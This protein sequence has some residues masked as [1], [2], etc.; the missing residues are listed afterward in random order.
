[1]AIKFA[2]LGCGRIGVLHARNL[3]AA[4]GARLEVVFD[5]NTAV[6]HD[7][8]WGGLAGVGTH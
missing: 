3:A 4:E 6:S 2:L 5:P 8:A 7:V 1:M